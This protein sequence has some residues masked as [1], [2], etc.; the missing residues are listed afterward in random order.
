MRSV[1]V[2]HSLPTLFFAIALLLSAVAS[3]AHLP[4][5]RALPAAAA[6]TG[7]A[8]V[9]QHKSI[10]VDSRR[11]DLVCDRRRVCRYCPRVEQSVMYKPVYG[12]CFS[13]SRSVAIDLR[14]SATRSVA[15]S[16]GSSMHANYA[17]TVAK[18]S[19]ASPMHSNSVG[20]TTKYRAA[21]CNPVT[22]YGCTGMHS[23]DPSSASVTHSSYVFKH[24]SIY[25]DSHPCDLVCVRRV[26]RYCR[27]TWY[28]FRY[29]PSAKVCYSPRRSIA[30]DMEYAAKHSVPLCDPFSGKG[31]I[32]SGMHSAHCDP[33]TG[34]G[35]VDNGMH[36]SGMPSQTVARSSYVFKHKSVYFD[37]YKC[38]LVCERRVCR[39]CRRIGRWFIFG[40]SKCY[41]PSRSVVI[42]MQYAAKHSVP[43]CVAYSGYGCSKKK[44]IVAHG[45]E[46]GVNA[47]IALPGVVPVVTQA[48][49]VDS[50]PSPSP[51][52]DFDLAPVVSPAPTFSPV[53][54]PA[55]SPAVSPD[56]NFGFANIGALF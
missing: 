2:I 54:S 52:P 9:F 46:Y 29:G 36:S 15:S 45:Y 19:Y 44:K 41:S 18:R 20:Y 28:P 22:G 14:Y 17:S 37:S 33:V 39:Y 50:A 47:T 24:K 34:Y 10:Y 48:A 23:S 3:A 8:H 13:A 4:Y 35:C 25:F 26:C 7:S 56:A 16:Y 55:V 21:S 43:S 6:A 32:N 31:C 49:D 38:D 53:V 30:I 42:D 11:C 40:Y 51:T 12:A 27:R 1:K 5:G